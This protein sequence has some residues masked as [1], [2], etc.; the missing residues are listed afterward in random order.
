[1][2]YKVTFNF[3]AW[4]HEYPDLH[5][6]T[7]L[8]ESFHVSADNEIEAFVKAR[9]QAEKFA[10][11]LG[12]HGTCCPASTDKEADIIIRECSPKDLDA[13]LEEIFSD[14]LLATL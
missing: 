6:D 12:Y 14:P 1:M 10:R 9:C 2:M 5:P 11:L 7:T 3:Q 4:A 8:R 13:E